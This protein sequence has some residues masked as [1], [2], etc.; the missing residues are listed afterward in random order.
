MHKHTQMLYNNTHC[1]FRAFFV[2]VPTVSAATYPRHRMF[3]YTLSPYCVSDTSR[4]RSGRRE[5]Y[6][7]YLC[8]GIYN[9]VRVSVHFNFGTRYKGADIPRPTGLCCTFLCAPSPKY[10]RTD[11]ARWLC[12]VYTS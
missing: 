9:K 4:H 12:Y 2:F 10:A 3:Y 11:F 1:N 8:T 5:N 6:V 7:Y